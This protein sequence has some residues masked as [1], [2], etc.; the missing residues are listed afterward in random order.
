MGPFG[1]MGPFAE[2]PSRV[3]MGKFVII[4]HNLLIIGKDHNFDR[5]GVAVIFSG[6]P[7]SEATT[8]EDD[9]WIGARVMIMRGITIGRGSIIAAGSVVTRDVAAYSIMAGVPARLVRKRFDEGEAT[10]HD[11]FLSQN[12]K[13]GG[14][15]PSREW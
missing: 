10:I 4:G 5:P 9:V 2:I 3:T 1:Y 13:Q 8:I 7:V 15:L 11:M 12:A 6:R 14:S